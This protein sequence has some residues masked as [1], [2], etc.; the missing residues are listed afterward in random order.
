MIDALQHFLPLARQSKVG[1]ELGLIDEGVIRPFAVFT[2]HRSHN[3]ESPQILNKLLQVIN[4][5][6]DMLPVIFPVH[7]RTENKL[8]DFGKQYHPQLRLL[9]PML[10]LDFLWLLSSAAVV[11]TD[12]GGIQEETTA[13]RVPCL[14]LRKATERPVTVREGTNQIV[15]QSPR[16]ILAAVRDVLSGRFKSGRV[17]ALWDGRAAQRIVKVLLNEESKVVTLREPPTKQA[18]AISEYIHIAT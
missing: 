7:P 12:S 14:T 18:S 10:Y 2:L 16:T 17:P 15:G 6:A 11:L 13:L 9:R 3:V 4:E 5:I 8:R 1:Y